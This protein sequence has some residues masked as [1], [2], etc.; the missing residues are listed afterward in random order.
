MQRRR[1]VGWTF[2]KAAASSDDALIIAAGKLDGDR[3]LIELMK[4][5]AWHER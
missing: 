4:T 1:V 2:D 3:A 5:I